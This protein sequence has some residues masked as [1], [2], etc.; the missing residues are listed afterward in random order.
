[1]KCKFLFLFLIVTGLSVSAQ[2][3]HFTQY[4]FAP[5][6]VNPAN[7]GN[8]NGSYRIGGIFRDQGFAISSSAAYKTINFYL[9]ATFPWRIRK[10][11]WMGF[12]LNFIQDRSGEINWGSGGFIAQ[13]SYHL[14]L[15][16]KSSLS[17]GGQYGFVNYNI[18][19]PDKAKF[20]SQILGTPGNP[21]ASLQNKAKYKDIT[22]GVNYLS[23]VGTAKHNLEL[24]ISAARINSPRVT[25]L[26]TGSGQKLAALLTANAGLIYHLNPKVDLRNYIWLRNL[27]SFTEFIP[28]SIVSY[29][30]N[31]EKGI[32]LNGGLGYRIGDALQVMIGA[33]IRNLSFQIALDQTLSD[34][35]S[36]QSPNGIGGVEFGIKYIGV[37]SKKPEPKPKVFCPRF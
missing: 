29:L 8:F 9:D 13:V 18:Q 7:V 26:S 37:V 1:M 11:D 31:V 14:F 24:G 19:N 16:P 3:V 6:H 34:L 28:Q 20:E 17:L 32:R 25:Q 35:A 27:K 21:N 12:G 10:N 15:N 30:F 5:L 33:D 2:D 23:V 22:L 36:A 4:S